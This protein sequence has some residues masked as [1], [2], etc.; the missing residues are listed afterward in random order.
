VWFSDPEH[1]EVER[2]EACMSDEDPVVRDTTR[3][4]L[5]RLRQVDG[6]LASRL[7]VRCRPPAAT[8]GTWRS[9]AA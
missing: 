1:S 7:A 5:L 3:I 4:P 6:K 9:D 2:L 8:T